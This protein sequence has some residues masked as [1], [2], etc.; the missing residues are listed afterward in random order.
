MFQLFEEHVMEPKRGELGMDEQLSGMVTCEQDE[1]L[2][3]TE[4]VDPPLHPCKGHSV[5]VLEV[6]VPP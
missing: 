5:T 3:P 2:H 4:Q 1:P 6:N